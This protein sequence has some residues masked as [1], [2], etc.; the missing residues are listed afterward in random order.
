MLAVNH[1]ENLSAH[2]L[3]AKLDPLPLVQ[4][5]EHSPAQFLNALRQHKIFFLHIE[6]LVKI[7]VVLVV[8]IP[9]MIVSYKDDLVEII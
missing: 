6:Q 3:I 8:R 1:V 7:Y 4:P 2:D 5:V 9:E